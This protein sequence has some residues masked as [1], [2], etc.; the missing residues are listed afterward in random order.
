[1]TTATS[2]KRQARRLFI[3]LAQVKA[4]RGLSPVA[5]LVAYEIGQHFNARYGGAAWPSSQT[6]AKNIGVGKAT[7]IRAVRQLRERGHLT[8]EP[9]RAGGPPGRGHSNRYRMAKPPRKGSSEHPLEP[10]KGSTGDA[11]GSTAVDLNYLE[12][13]TGPHSA[14]PVGE[15]G[16]ELKLAAVPGALAPH[17][18]ARDDSKA[19]IEDR[20]GELWSL[21]SS[22][23]SWPDSYLEKFRA[24]RAFTIA[25]READPG[26]II[27]AAGAWVGAV[28]ARYLSTLSKWLLG[29]G[30]QKPPPTRRRSGGKVSLANLALHIGSQGDRP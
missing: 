26:A 7:V 17:G 29:R 28:D 6:I 24:R 5:F 19:L 9:G 25:C 13:P 4:D 14:V 21:W 11:K 12:L 2:S 22:T 23:R 10:E 3:W 20:F 18:G 27:A 15:S 30:W 16:S 1:M 8:V